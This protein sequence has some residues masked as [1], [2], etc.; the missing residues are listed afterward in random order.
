MITWQKIEGALV[1]L[2]A[3]AVFIPLDTGISWWLALLVFFAPDL[4]FAGYALGNRVGSALYNIVHVYAL[5][6][7]VAALGYWFD[8]PMVT[9]IGVLL[10]AHTGFDRMMGYGLKSIEGF[11]VTHLGRIG[12]DQ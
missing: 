1:F 3:L 9:G 10:F 6:V 7:V 12:K 2:I 8:L 11:H 5:G 4:S